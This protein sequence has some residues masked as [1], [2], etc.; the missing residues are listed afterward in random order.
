MVIGNRKSMSFI[1][2]TILIFSAMHE[3]FHSIIFLYVMPF[4]SVRLLK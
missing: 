2:A 1:M 4:G 3:D